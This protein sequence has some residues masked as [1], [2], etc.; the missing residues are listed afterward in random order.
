MS[1]GKP[2]VIAEAGVN[3]NGD[4]ALAV[5]L[6]DAAADAGAD[7]VKF[8]TFRAESLASADAPTAAYQKERAGGESQCAMLK[9]LELSEKGHRDALARARARGI[10]FLSTPFDEDSADFLDSLDIPRFK[11]PSGEVTNLSFLRH[12]AK[13]G[14]PII[15][16][17]GMSTL[18]EVRAAVETLRANGCRD[19]TLLHCVSSYP[20]ESADSNLNAMRTLA[21]TFRVPVGWSD[22]TTGTTT[23]IA[24]VALGA[25]VLEKHFTLDKSLPGPDHAMS[26]NP[27]ELKA[28][29]AVARETAAALGD[30]IKAP[31]AV[32]RPI[33]LVARK[34]LVLRKALPQ[35]T[36]LRSD[37]LTAKRPGTGIS[38]ALLDQLVGKRLKID[39]PA[40][41]PLVWEDFN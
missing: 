15:L 23:A 41:R 21:E 10:I 32:E 36:I 11:L 30:G 27:A 4:D 29:V 25:A 17:T 24:A 33:A 37:D 5:K 9:K 34:S 18:E 13:K 16:S 28:Y 14:R 31:R 3:H 1:T 6:V 40:D 2:F 19:L 39:T 35:G 7:A 26:L 8:Q 38:P 22:H 12:V 20:A